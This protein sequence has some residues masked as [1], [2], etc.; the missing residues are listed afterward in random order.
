V[1]KQITLVQIMKLLH[2]SLLLL[3]AAAFTSP[4]MSQPVSAQTSGYGYD[5]RQSRPLNSNQPGFV[6]G[7]DVYKPVMNRPD[8]DNQNQKAPNLL[9]NLNYFGR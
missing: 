4:F 7:Y 8:F 2:F 5:Y 9:N 6:P 1:P 3:G